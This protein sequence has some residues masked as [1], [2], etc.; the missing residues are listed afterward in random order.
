[1]PYRP[2]RNTQRLL[3]KAAELAFAA[4]QVVAHRV[5][6][7]AIAGPALS[8]RDR[9]EFQRMGAEKTAAFSEAWNAMA[10]QALH[11]NH[12]LTMSLVRSLWSPSLHG[13]PSAGAVAAQLHNAALAV[14]GEGMA[15][16]HRRAVANARRLARTKLR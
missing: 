4:P 15:P 11:S 7:M 5:T 3:A 10:K 6:R 9:K 12:A 13:K 1:M 16:V 8:E 2:K 14:L